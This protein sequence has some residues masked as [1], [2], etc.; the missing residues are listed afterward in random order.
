M[1]PREQNPAERENVVITGASM[2]VSDMFFHNLKTEELDVVTTGGRKR[3]L[4]IDYV[5]RTY[6]YIYT[7]TY[8]FEALAIGC[9]CFSQASRKIKKSQN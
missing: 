7:C 2:S 3:A 6:I 9:T 5:F 1:H 8:M 4:Y